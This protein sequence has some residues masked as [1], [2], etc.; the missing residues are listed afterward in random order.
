MSARM[1]SKDRGWRLHTL[2]GE[3]RVLHVLLEHALGVEV[4]AIQRNSRA[5]D[6]PPLVRLLIIEGKD[7]LIQ[8]VVERLRLAGV[9]V[10]IGYRPAGDAFDPA[11]DPPAVEDAETGHTVEG[12]LHAAGSRGFVGTLGRVE[13]EIYASGEQGAESPLIVFEIDDLQQ[14][15]LQLVGQFDDAANHGLAGLVGGVGLATVD[16]LQAAELAGALDQAIGDR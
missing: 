8:V 2:F 13:P 12:S 16:D 3:I 6:A 7:Y 15:G 10:V 5:H 11:F 9:L 14:I 4:R 1:G